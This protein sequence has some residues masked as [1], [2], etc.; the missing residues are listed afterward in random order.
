M[1]LLYVHFILHELCSQNGF[2]YIPRKPHNNDR[3]KDFIVTGR[4]VA[5]N[6]ICLYLGTSAMVNLSI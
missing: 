2:I 6:Q 5:C 1:L 3:Q 4:D